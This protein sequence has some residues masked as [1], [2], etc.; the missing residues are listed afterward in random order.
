MFDWYLF[1]DIEILY[2]GKSTG[3][4]LN[5]AKN[6]N[7]WGAITSSVKEGDMVLVTS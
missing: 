3:N 7:K 5:R 1:D 2:I 4:V 6:H